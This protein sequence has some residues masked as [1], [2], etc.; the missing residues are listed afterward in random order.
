MESDL[1]KENKE[2]RVPEWETLDMEK[3]EMEPSVWLFISSKDRIIKKIKLKNKKGIHRANWDF[4]TQSITPVT[5]SNIDRKMSGPKAGIGTYSSQVFK[6]IN[7]EYTAISTKKDFNLKPLEKG[8]L[9]GSS[10][11]EV[12][13]FWN[14]VYKLRVKA[15]EL[16]DEIKNSKKEIDK[17]IK[18]YQQAKTTNTALEKRIY[19]IR[20]GFNKLDI[21][22]N[23]SK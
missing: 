13:A 4:S 22:L 10:N 9:K 17:I 20:D 15:Y 12:V 18:S 7:G 19:N 6:M 14:D 23:G 8:A 3:M 5:S 21:Q 2:V 11:T 1:E 16:S